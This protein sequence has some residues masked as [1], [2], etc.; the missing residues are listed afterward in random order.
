[1]RE[2]YRSGLAEKSVKIKLLSKV[3]AESD[4]ELEDTLE[5]IYEYLHKLAGSSAM[6]GYD[7]I[8]LLCQNLMRNV[9]HLPTLSQ[10]GVVLNQLEQLQNLLEQHA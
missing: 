10:L 2:A 5:S 7:D 6:Y 3:L 1:M 8:A 4:V 9:H